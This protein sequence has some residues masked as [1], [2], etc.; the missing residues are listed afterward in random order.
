MFLY[1]N[2]VNVQRYQFSTKRTFY[3]LKISILFKKLSRNPKTKISKKTPKK[4]LI[5]T[6]QTEEKVEKP[7][8]HKPILLKGN[9]KETFLSVLNLPEERKETVSKEELKKNAAK[10]EEKFSNFDIGKSVIPYTVI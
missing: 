1:G 5:E 7:V 3:T 8:K 2:N 4:K 9:D 6:A 10:L